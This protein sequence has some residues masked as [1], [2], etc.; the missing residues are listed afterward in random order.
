MQLHE[1]IRRA[2]KELRL[3][4][5]ELAKLSGVQR[6]QLSSLENGRNVTLRTVRKVLAHLPNI[7]RFTLAPANVEVEPHNLT[8]SDWDRMTKTMLMIADMYQKMNAHMAAYQAAI[9]AG[10]HEEAERLIA[11]MGQLPGPEL[12][13]RLDED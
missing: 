8:R 11:E 6:R 13:K 9:E 7:Q 10:N 1:E 12:R 3:S 4:Q 5:A 2:R